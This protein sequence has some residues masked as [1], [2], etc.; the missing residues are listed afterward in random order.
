M[1]FKSILLAIVIGT[2]CVCSQAQIDHT[3]HSADGTK[4]GFVDAN[5][6]WI[7]S[8]QWDNASWD[9]NLQV[10]IVGNFK[11]P[12]G[13]VN[14][15]GDFILPMKYSKIRTNPQSKTLIVAEER[16]GVTY[17]GLF[18]NTGNPVLPLM[19][20]TVIF[21]RT[22]CLFECTTTDDIKKYFGTDGQEVID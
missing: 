11:G 2:T 19:Y 1:S 8:A 10:G 18:D 3:S 22:K 20:K 14:A 17:W 15:K 4:Y 12:K 21:N 5:D 9:A 16:D 6:N 7:L 13:A